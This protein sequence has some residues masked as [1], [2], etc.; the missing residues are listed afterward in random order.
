MLKCIPSDY[1]KKNLMRSLFLCAFLTAQRENTC[2]SVLFDDVYFDKNAK[3]RPYA[4]ITF[5]TTKGIKSN[6]DIR[7]TIM[8]NTNDP[9]M[10]FIK[11]IEDYLKSE[12]GI[13]IDEFNYIR[14]KEMYCKKKFGI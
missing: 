3:G 7:R 1:Q 4:T 12:Y 5:N 6:A 8:A 13:L 9:E 10:C 14:N 11:A 2:V